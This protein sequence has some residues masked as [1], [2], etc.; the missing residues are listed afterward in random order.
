MLT[1]AQVLTE[2][3]KTSLLT[4]NN[5]CWSYSGT[6]HIVYFFKILFEIQKHNSTMDIGE[7]NSISQ[8]WFLRTI[9]SIINV[10]KNAT[11]W[12]EEPT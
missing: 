5:Y 9:S 10:A 7:I 3:E 1:S 2:V 11:K 8:V 4:Y 12:L 6:K